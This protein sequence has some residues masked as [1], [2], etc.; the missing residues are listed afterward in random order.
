MKKTDNRGVS[1][2]EL[3]VAVCIMA[4]IVVPLLH[5][6]VTSYR[7][8]ARSR[9][10][11]RATTLA[12][13]EM[14]I[15]EKEKIADIADPE[16]FAYSESRK[17]GYRV[18]APENAADNGCY[19]FSRLGIIND[20]SGREEFDVYIT[21]NPLRADSHERYYTQNSAKLLSMNTISAV[22]S[23]T[24]VQRIRTENNEVDLDTVAY[25]FF[26]TN[27]KV[28][29]SA[30]LDEIKQNVKRTITVDMSREVREIGTFTVAKVSYE[31]ECSTFI[32]PEDKK[33][34]RE[35]QVIYNNSQNLDADGNPVELKSLYLFY[36]PRYGI[37]D[38]NKADTVIVNNTDGIA[39][40]IYIVRQ[41]LLAEGG[42][43]IQVTPMNYVAK[44]EI[45]DV[46]D[47]ETGKCAARYH[48]NLNVNEVPAEG[49]GQPVVIRLS[50]GETM[51]RDEVIA[52]T[53]LETL[54]E[55]KAKDRIY[56]MTVEV[57]ENG[58]NPDTDTPVVTLS[59]T[60]LE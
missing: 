34:Y 21:L 28:T 5:S 2:V 27:K 23:G 55:T 59:G 31:Y 39:A 50:G 51:L 6:F 60:K 45:H 4:I 32:V 19:R 44:L 22:D 7:M 29:S 3:L 47:G 53:G 14:E 52:A 57:Y 13:N 11:M 41:D 56:E 12:Q 54:G 25:N 9:K 30:T 18:K 33:F 58:A 48:T 40:D 15:F 37:M 42:S 35:E 1:L 43:N 16:K 49:L 36:A 20:G 38:A 26:N 46:P 8:N 17:D 10:T 24:Y